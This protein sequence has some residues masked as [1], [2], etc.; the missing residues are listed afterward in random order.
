ML[1]QKLTA[2]DLQAFT[3]HLM[4]NKAELSLYLKTPTGHLPHALWSNTHF[5]HSPLEDEETAVGGG[6]GGKGGNR[7]LSSAYS[8]PLLDHSLIVAEGLMKL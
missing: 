5:S 8:V 6:E 3:S 7:H 1:L 4:G 2:C